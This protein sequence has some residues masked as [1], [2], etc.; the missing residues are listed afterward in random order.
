MALAYRAPAGANTRL[1]DTSQPKGSRRPLQLNQDAQIEPTARGE[2][3][4][5]AYEPGGAD[6]GKR[7][8][9]VPMSAAIFALCLIAGY[10]I[11]SF[12]TGY[13]VAKAYGVNIQKVGSGNIGATNVLRSVGLWPAV[14]VVLADPIKAMLAILLAD[15]SGVSEWGLV[16]AGLAAVLGNNFNVFLGWRGGKG[17]ATSLGVGLAIVPVVTLAV[18]AV[19]VLTIALGRYVSL[20]SLVALFSAPLFLVMR[21]FSVPQLFLVLSLLLLVFIRHRENIKRLAEGTERRLGDKGAAVDT[22]TP[23]SE[24]EVSGA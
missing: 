19:G 18:G 16:L 7:V 1:A 22:T 2:H 10:L 24:R 12:P 13:F 11:G 17:V 23:P 21:P 4:Q 3:V 8:E 20:G 14:L 9:G 5:S 6:A 15:L